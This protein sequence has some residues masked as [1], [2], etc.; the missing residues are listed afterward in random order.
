[1]ADNRD[2]EATQP[3]VRSAKIRK[4]SGILRGVNAGGPERDDN[5]PET[6]RASLGKY[7]LLAELGSGGM[8]TVFLAVMRGQSGFN[9]LVVVKVLKPHLAIEEEVV[10]MFHDEARL[11]A[12]LNH[13]NVVQTYE[14]GR[15]DGHHMMVMEYLDGVAL[16]Q[17]S[18]RA[19]MRSQNL[20]LGMYLRL[21]HSALDGLHY[22]HELTDYNGEPLGVV[23]RDISPHNV[24][25][26][27]DGQVKI[28][29]FGIAKLAGSS[30]DT[31]AGT[32]KGKIRYM[33]PEQMRGERV[34]RRADIF[35]VGAMLW[36]AA[37][38]DRLWKGR[39]DVE[40]MNQVINHEIPSPRSVNA[41]ISETL[42]RICQKALAKE[43]EDRY[44]TCVELQADLEKL[45]E[46]LGDKTTPRDITKFL[47]R[48]F[49]D[50]R[51][52]RKRIIEQQLTSA[53]A[54]GS[55]YYRAVTSGEVEVPTLPALPAYS[56][57][58]HSIAR[59][60]GLPV[61]PSRPSWA[62][63][64]VMALLVAGALFAILM[65]PARELPAPAASTPTV[66][67]APLPPPPVVEPFV[68]PP[69]SPAP[70][71]VVSA[72]PSPSPSVIA[73]A[74]PAAPK[75]VSTATPTP[76]PKPSASINKKPARPIDSANPWND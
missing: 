11:S 52:E 71:P 12:R 29:D 3:D 16:N 67:S 47:A 46:E 20:P 8:A 36:E 21:I 43:P 33:A 1:M 2:E 72:A 74:K 24:F 65:R 62:I 50:V 42:D 4:K 19:R 40:I 9:K 64:T 54:L 25:V 22:A 39:G 73:V 57:G 59:P 49:A 38:G 31:R 23:H 61:V 53:N 30:H 51:D 58:S 70:E 55:G 60:F 26:T 41:A 34:D 68:A 66:A 10:S 17:L 37:T 15:E 18:E 69:P 5:E 13:P 48:E 14:V 28:L 44:A 56:S 6:I 7:R 32:I 76:D 35:A 75:P 63:P 45:L 27:F